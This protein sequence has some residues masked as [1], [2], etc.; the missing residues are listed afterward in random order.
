M[1]DMIPEEKNGSER[2]ITFSDVEPVDETVRRP[3]PIVPLLTVVITLLLALYGG[4]YMVRLENRAKKIEPP[5][6]QVN[7]LGPLTRSHRAP[8]VQITPI[9]DA[10]KCTQ[11]DLAG[12]IVL[13][14]FWGTWCGPC[15]IEMPR[16]D[17]LYM[18]CKDDPNIRIIS[19]S[20]PMGEAVSDEALTTLTQKYAKDQGFT[21]PFYIDSSLKTARLYNLAEFPTN[22]IIDANGMIVYQSTG[23]SDEEWQKLMEVLAKQS[24]ELQATNEVT[25]LLAPLENE[26]TPTE[27]S[28]TEVVP[29]DTT[30]ETIEPSTSP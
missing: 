10:P 4:W 24:Q 29:A 21:M 17:R 5:V 8:P 15:Q 13:L 7:D 2:K 16:L 27:T 12:K 25:Q 3:T 28:Q 18:N 26:T 9:G 19:I 22:V 14:N 11:E 1:N 6:P 20:Y 30:T 23:C